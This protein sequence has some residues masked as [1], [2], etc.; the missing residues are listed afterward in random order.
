M[1]VGDDLR[2]ARVDRVAQ[3]GRPIGL[4]GARAKRTQPGQIRRML[5][6]GRD[7][8]ELAFAGLAL[9]ALCSGLSFLAPLALLASRKLWS[10]YCLEAEEFGLRESIRSTGEQSADSGRKKDNRSDEHGCAAITAFTGLTG[11]TDLMGLTGLT[12]LTAYDHRFGGKWVNGPLRVLEVEL[13]ENEFSF[14]K[15]QGRAL[16]Q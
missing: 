3:A 13:K 16:G 14:E 9:L 12:A 10:R 5:R 4:L 11:L 6:S 8:E 15:K 1:E 2:R 7:A